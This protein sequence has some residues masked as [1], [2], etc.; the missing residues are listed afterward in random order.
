MVGGLYLYLYLSPYLNTPYIDNVNPTPYLIL[1]STKMTSNE[2]GPTWLG[3][4]NAAFY[5]LKG[6]TRDWAK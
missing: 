2:H 1:A 3:Q 4:I 5:I 6:K